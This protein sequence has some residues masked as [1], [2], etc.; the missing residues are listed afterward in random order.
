MAA[1]RFGWATTAPPKLGFETGDAPP[2]SFLRARPPAPG[3]PAPLPPA[4][5]VPPLSPHAP[6][7]MHAPGSMF[8]MG[9]PA[10]GGM[11]VHGGM[12]ANGGM[13]VHTGVPAHGGMPAH[14]GMP[15]HSGTPV[16]AGTPAPAGMQGVPGM[17]RMAGSV[18]RADGRAGSTEV[19]HGAFGVV[20]SVSRG[21]GGSAGLGAGS[22]RRAVL[23]GINY[24]W[25]VGMTRLHGAV[26]DVRMLHA[27]LVRKFGYRCEDIWVLTDELHGIPGPVPHY[28]PTRA[29]ILHSMRWV[30]S[31]ARAGDSAF[32][33]FSG[34]GGQVVDENGDEDDG[35]DEVI[36]PS[37]FPTA[38]NIVDDDI[39]DI[40]VRGLC[41]GA[42]LTTLFD[43]CNSGTVMD[44]PYVHVLDPSGNG[45]FHLHDAAASLPS[46]DLEMRSPTG[47]AIS[48]IFGSRSRK[49]N[50]ALQKSV[51]KRAEQKRQAVASR[52]L[53]NGNVVSFSSCSDSQKSADAFAASTSM[54]AAGAMTGAFSKCLESID[55]SQTHLSYRSLLEAMTRM[56]QR[57]GHTQRPQFNTSHAISLDSRF[58]I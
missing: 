8:P 26:N 35:W 33:S 4:A 34:H 22:R 17:R 6:P 24:T 44:L 29:N 39:H 54:H 49:R 42:N 58:V 27:M 25:T 40:M 55:L 3:P 14:V 16:H 46:D 57:A 31:G 21:V 15:T 51:R 9:M 37:D 50:K 13:P 47:A 7:G 30:A 20:P 2:P 45:T 48:A 1:P 41:N 11:P 18:L 12:P 5:S 10:H 56:M 23:V 28:T 36:C 32:F 53:Y 43:C 52:I 38:G 19:G